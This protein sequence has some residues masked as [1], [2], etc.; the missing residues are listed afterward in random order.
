[1][2]SLVDDY[3]YRYLHDVFPVLEGTKVVGCV[4]KK[5]VGNSIAGSIGPDKIVADIM[6]VLSP[7]KTSVAAAMPARHWLRWIRRD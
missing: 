6:D 7:E 4:S 2:Q 3:L 1:M 5:Q